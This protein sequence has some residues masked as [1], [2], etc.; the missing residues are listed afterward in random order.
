MKKVNYTLRQLGPG[1]TGT[2]AI[3]ATSRTGASDAASN[4][5]RKLGKD[6]AIA[7][8]YD[9]PNHMFGANW[10]AYRLPEVPQ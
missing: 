9:A 3:L 7:V 2:I 4:A 10:L 1:E 5:R 6:V 8:H